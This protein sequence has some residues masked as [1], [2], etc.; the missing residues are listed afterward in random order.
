M[1]ENIPHER[2]LA[3]IDDR[4]TREKQIASTNAELSATLRRLKEECQRDIRAAIGADKLERYDKAHERMKLRFADLASATRHTTEG[5]RFASQMRQ[6][7]LTEAKQIVNQFGID[8]KKIERIQKKYSAE[9]QSAVERAFMADEEAPYVEVSPANAP[10]RIHNPWKWFSPPFFSGFG[11]SFGSGTRGT[12]SVS[13]F[14]NAQ[15]GEINCLSDTN[16]VGADDSDTNQ[17]M[18]YSEL[19]FWF[20]MPKAGLVEVWIYLQAID[21]PYGG[22]L[23]DEWGFSGAIVQQRSR[24]YLTIMA[25]FGSVRFGTMLDYVRG[26]QEGFWGSTL[27]SPGDNRYVHLFSLDSYAA[28]DQ[29]LCGVGIQDYNYVWV[30]DMSCFT[31]MTTRWFVQDVAVRSTGAP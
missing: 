14:E 10:T 4:A 25:P 22:G 11:V 2:L 19:D 5:L 17:T 26:E 13:H 12:R 20:T 23:N 16:I 9:A 1:V 21:T 6:Q 27:A 18:A 7:Y 15:T 3:A 29:L 28:G 30:N 8:T 24:P 31:H